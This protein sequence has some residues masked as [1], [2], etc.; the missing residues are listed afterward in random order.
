MKKMPKA[1][2][3]GEGKPL[4]TQAPDWLDGLVDE[5]YGRMA[6][7]EHSGFAFLLEALHKLFP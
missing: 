5:V 4:Q 3:R 6:Q 2:E 7:G 1:R